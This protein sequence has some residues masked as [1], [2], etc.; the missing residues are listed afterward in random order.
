MYKQRAL[1]LVIKILIL[2]THFS[3]RSKNAKNESKPPVCVKTC[4]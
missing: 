2:I 4:S 1:K 3:Y